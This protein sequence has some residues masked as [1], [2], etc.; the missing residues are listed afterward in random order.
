M[1]LVEEMKWKG[2]RVISKAKGL[3]EGGDGGECLRCAGEAGGVEAIVIGVVE[4]CA[5]AAVAVD[6]TT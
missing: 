1:V 5:A 4:R 3:I 6:C 2:T